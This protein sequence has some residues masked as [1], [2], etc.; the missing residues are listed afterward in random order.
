MTIYTVSLCAIDYNIEEELKVVTVDE[1]KAYRE[2]SKLSR[3]CG[4]LMVYINDYTGED[5]DDYIVLREW[6]DEEEGE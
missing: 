2:A 6:D 4:N 1:A 3:E 5:Y